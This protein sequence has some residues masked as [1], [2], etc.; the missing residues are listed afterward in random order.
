MG[1]RP[2][3]PQTA[4]R[5]AFA[6]QQLLRLMRGE[7]IVTEGPHAR[8]ASVTKRSNGYSV[9]VRFVGGSSPFHLQP[10][11]NCTVC[12]SGAEGDFD[13]SHDGR[14]WAPGRHAKMDGPNSVSFQVCLPSAPTLVRYTAGSNFTQCALY[15]GEAL[16]AWPFK[17]RVSDNA[18]I[19]VV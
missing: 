4:H 7:K 11:R 13:A 15:N 1:V 9:S 19:I 8:G 17:M 6:A 12:C 18:S 10:T 14:F 2:Q 5:A 16:P 3:C